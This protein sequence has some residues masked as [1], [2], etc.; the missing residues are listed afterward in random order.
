[1]EK[2]SQLLLIN[3][4]IIDNCILLLA[5]LNKLYPAGKWL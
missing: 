4:V 5:E 2:A 3:K 1:M